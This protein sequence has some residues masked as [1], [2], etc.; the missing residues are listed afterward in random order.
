MIK[1]I[2]LKRDTELDVDGISKKM[3]IV[4]VSVDTRFTKNANTWTTQEKTITVAE[5]LQNEFHLFAK[6]LMKT[7][8]NKKIEYQ[9][10]FAVWMFGRL[11]TMC[12]EIEEL[13]NKL[14]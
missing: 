2:N 8:E 4:D 11:A 12:I 6:E 5:N 1:L 9:D 7:N 10:A 14:K 3:F 13:K